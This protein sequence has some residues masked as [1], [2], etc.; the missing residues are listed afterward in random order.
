MT[1]VE[2]VEVAD[3]DVDAVG[4]GIDGDGGRGGAELS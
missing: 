1:V 4:Y 3:A 2:Q